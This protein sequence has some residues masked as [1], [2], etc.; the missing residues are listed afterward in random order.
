MSIS[1]P[2][3]P[4]TN[5][6]Y[7]Y[8]NKVWVYNG[9]RWVSTGSSNPVLSTVPVVVSATQPA[10]TVT[11]AM[12]LN[13]TSNTISIYNGTTWAATSVTLSANSVQG[14]AIIDHT[15]TS[16][17]LSSN[18][19]L[20][21]TIT[22]GNITATNATLGNLATANYFIGS[23]NNLSN[24]QGANVSGAVSFATTANS[25]AGANVSGAVSSAT[26][27]TTATTAGTVT[28]AAQ[29][30][31]TSLGTLTSLIMAG[32]VSETFDTKTGATGT[33]VHDVSI[34]STFYHTSPAAN[35][36]ANFTNVSTT[37]SKIT[38]VA[39]V[40]AQG[41]TAYVP[42][43]MQIAGT[44]QT[45]TWL[46]GSAPTGNANKYDMISYN[47]FRIGSSWSVFG[48]LSTFG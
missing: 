41:A 39:V 23:G 16:T 7:T 1:F 43:T 33:V 44:T 18:L 12:W 25:V 40:I 3:N 32:P 13:S 45:V 27:A 8:A 34:A 24:I 30:N 26:T 47:M 36:T 5:D 46:G 11:G 31:I 14:N 35:F 15:L 20:A 2:S 10:I 19:T 17:Q 37:S 9:A 42:T 29:A 21:G 28:S 38:V 48:S 6:T 4:A 22:L